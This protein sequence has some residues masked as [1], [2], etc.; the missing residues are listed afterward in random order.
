MEI[1]HYSIINI[2]RIIIITFPILIIVY[3][4]VHPPDCVIEKYFPPIPWG[5]TYTYIIHLFVSKLQNFEDIYQ[6][7]HYMRS[8]KR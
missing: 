7:N 1:I 8:Y 3:I 5:F 6:D 2:M 4:Q